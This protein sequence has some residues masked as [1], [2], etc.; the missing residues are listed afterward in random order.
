MSA[1]LFLLLSKLKKNYL[2]YLLSII[3]TDFFKPSELQWGVLLLYNNKIVFSSC[4]GMPSRHSLKSG[5][6][7]CVEDFNPGKDQHIWCFH[8]ALLP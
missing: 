5:L 4:A 3:L 7:V 6:L 2:L 1:I 8:A